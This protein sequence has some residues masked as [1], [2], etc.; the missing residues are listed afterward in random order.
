MGLVAVFTIV[1]MGEVRLSLVATT[2]KMEKNRVE[3][4]EKGTNK[5]YH[6]KNY[7]EL[8]ASFFGRGIV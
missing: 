5:G 4:N 6:R 8:V 1:E 3:I 7:F 2:S